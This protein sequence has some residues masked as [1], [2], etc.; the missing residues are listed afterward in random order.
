MSMR[1]EARRL[2]VGA[3]LLAT[4]VAAPASAAPLAVYTDSLSTLPNGFQNWSWGTFANQSAV[5]HGGTAAISFEP[6]FW[7]GLFFHL[8]G[9]WSL[10]TYDAVDFWIKGAT[11]GVQLRVMPVL[12]N[13][14]IG[15]PAPVA[16][17]VP[18]VATSWTHVHIAFGAMG[19]FPHDAIDGIMIQDTTGG[20]QP[21]VYVDDIQLTDTTPPAETPGATVAVTVDPAANVRP[22]DPRIYGVNFGDDAQAQALHWPI[23]RWGGNST[24]RYNWKIDVHNTGSD[25]FFM[26]E[27]DAALDPNTLPEGSTADQF[28][29]ST[30][31][32]GGEPILTVPLIGWTPA[33]ALG[34]NKHWGFSVGKYGPQDA[35]ECTASG[36][37]SWCTGDAG[38][39]VHNGVNLTG[40]SPS[41]TSEAITPAF[42]TDWMD[43]L[44]NRAGGDVHYLALDNEPMLWNSTHRD[45][46]PAATT[47]DE[48]WGR[49]QSYAAAMKAKDASVQILGPVLWGWCAYFWSAA[50]N[51]GQNPVDH[52]AHGMDFVPWYL[53]Q[54]QSY[55]TAHGVRLVDF[56]DLHYYPQNDG[57]SLSGEGTTDVQAMRL[58]SLKSLYDPAYVDESWIASAQPGTVIRMIPRMHDWVNTYFPGTK[59]AITEYNWGN[60]ESPSAALAQAEALAIF[61]REGL[62]LA[63]RWVAPAAGSRVED[64]FRLYLDYDGF[65]ARIAGSSVGA[66]SANVDQVGSYAVKSA[67]GTRL[68]VLLFNKDSAPHPATVSLH[69][70]SFPQPAALYRFAPTRPLASAGTV[71]PAGGQFAL[72]L[73]ARS[74]TLLVADGMAPPPEASFYTLPP[75]RVLDTRSPLG[76]F[77]GPALTAGMQRSFNFAG[78]CGVPATARAVAINAT[79]VG[80]TRG[81]Y[82]TAFPAGGALPATSVISF[83]AG[84]VRANN[85]VLAVSP[86]GNAALTFFAGLSSSPASVNL[87]VDVTGYFE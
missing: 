72:T 15:L 69:T 8:N 34:R 82:L 68:W 33:T 62:D 66:T 4:C 49:T 20:N 65:G 51:C 84:A 40:N 17:E 78:R 55:Q 76:D 59:L 47:Y 3:V 39:G 81:G 6:D 53:Q 36:Y 41:D 79:V 38:N 46:H 61:G 21:T 32:A 24:T 57:V 50:D 75:C 31:A 9:G 70:G 1:S 54:A 87:V 37:P 25:W 86:D 56:L 67:D 7:A 14:V 85:A 26:N 22:I 77:G 12:G 42:V 30:R 52:D 19:L 63:T 10:T 43:H 11:N 23:R 27:P 28:V 16:A 13:S 74:A 35:T 45:V 80:A 2:L 48:L 58:R 5:V 71:T 73:P 44:T 83:A 64:A 60:D 29:D 18:A